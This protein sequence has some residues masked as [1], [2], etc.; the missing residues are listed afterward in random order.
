MN[1]SQKSNELVLAGSGTTFRTHIFELFGNKLKKLILDF[2][3]VLCSDTDLLELVFQTDVCDV[4]DTFLRVNLEV[5]GRSPSLRAPAAHGVS[6][7]ASC[8]N[9]KRSRFDGGCLHKWGARR[10]I[11]ADF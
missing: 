6:S 1:T 7:R 5:P 8:A 10:K 9:R 4:R 2:G 11:E 3:L